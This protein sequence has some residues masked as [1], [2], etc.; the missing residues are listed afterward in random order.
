MRNSSETRFY[1][2]NNA[3]NGYEPVVRSNHPGVAERP[4]VSFMMIRLR[5]S[6]VRERDTHGSYTLVR[7][8]GGNTENWAKMAYVR[9]DQCV[10]CGPN[11]SSEV[12]QTICHKCA[13]SWHID[14]DIRAVTEDQV[15]RVYQILTESAVLRRRATRQ[16]QMSSSV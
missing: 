5:P 4:K 14:W 12:E 10:T 8:I 15:V 13:E 6:E 7:A 3:E 11:A 2:P 16:Y 9:S 1:T